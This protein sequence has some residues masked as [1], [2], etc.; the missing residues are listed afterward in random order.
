MLIRLLREYLRPYTWA[1]IAA[2]FGGAGVA[3]EESGEPMAAA[4]AGRS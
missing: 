1:L 4:A 3:G 2:Q